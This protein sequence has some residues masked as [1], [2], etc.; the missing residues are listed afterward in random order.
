M[1]L[2]F[3][4]A[5]VIV[6]G[7]AVAE[8][9]ISTDI[10]Q[11]VPPDSLLV[12]VFDGRPD[13]PSM[14]AF[15]NAQ[16]PEAHDLWMKQETAMRK[17]VE[18][19]A[20]LFGISLD[21][22][23]DIE[24]WDGQQWALVIL[25]EGEDGNMQPVL[26][27]ASNDAAAANAA[28]EKISAPWQRIGEVT[29]VTDSD[30]P[31]TAFMME[32][33]HLEIYAS[34]YG[35]VLAISPS[36]TC[37]EQALSGNGFAAG[38]PGE[39]ALAE[40]SDSMLC[41]YV[42]SSMLEY[43]DVGID[44]IPFNSFGL[45]IS[46]VEDGIKVRMLGLLHSEPAFFLKQMMPEQPEEALAVNPGIPSASLAAAAF[47]DTSGLAG[48]AGMFDIEGPIL[49]IIQALD[50]I[51][52]SAALTA[53]LPMP[54]GVV[55]V[56]A[57][58]EDDAAD[59]L[60][61]ITASLKQLRITTKPRTLS[62]IETTSVEIPYG[63]TMYLAQIGK[64]VIVASDAQSLAGA[65]AAISGERLSLADSVTYEETMA[66]LGE[67]NLLTMYINLAPIQG[68]GFLVDGLGF[69][70]LD[71]VYGAVAKGLENMQALGLGMGLSG[72]VISATMFL[73]ADPGMGISIAPTAISAAAIGAAVL[74]PVFAK[75]RDAEQ[76]AEC[77]SNLKQLIT[78]VIVYSS[79]H[80]GKL[81]TRTEWQTQLED[82]TYLY[83]CPL[84]KSIYA[85]NKNLGGLNIN[86]ILNP[87]EVVMFFEADPGLPNA[88]GS[89]A[90]AVLP[91]DGYGWFAYVDGHVEFLSEAPAQYHWVPKYAAPK[92]VKKAPV[93]KTT[94]H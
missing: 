19:F 76:Q 2:I 41:A 52:I 57:T 1:V 79:D 32:D 87:S 6:G 67:S 85:F 9:P 35:Q 21:F 36:K 30:Y 71:P 60:A 61:R 94:R 74:V 46:I 7:A 3:L 80:K 81:P 44:E 72:D 4:L 58:S 56:M 24:S 5:V 92:A 28:L 90:N 55:S 34:A 88:S 25:P 16:T 13:S 22:A 18:S 12:V 86:N 91:H 62:E 17:A 73:R 23:K 42:D 75:A 8:Q 54:A 26:M 45:G 89:R 31:I 82:Y 64:H 51:Q 84:G 20:T 68:L 40:I 27:F 59:K 49:N 65:A 15:T 53:V 78:D 70:R 83:E 38:S 33:E 69:S 93:K 43:L 66:N 47:P 63:P 77:A 48:M 11:L 50:D 10:R 14:Q 39:K 29:P 37:L